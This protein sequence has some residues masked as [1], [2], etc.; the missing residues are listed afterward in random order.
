MLALL[1]VVD[2]LLLAQFGGIGGAT[3]EASILQHLTLQQACYGLELWIAKSHY[4]MHL[5]KML[6]IFCLLLCA[7]KKA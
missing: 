5:G 3:L 6:K 4:V 2:M 1:V 7:R